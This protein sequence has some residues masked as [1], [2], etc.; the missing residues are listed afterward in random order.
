MSWTIFGKWYY[1]YFIILV[2]TLVTSLF[3]RPL[4]E[5]DSEA[6]LWMA[7]TVAQAFGA[8]MAIVIAIGLFEKARNSEQLSELAKE[9]DIRKHDNQ[10]NVRGEFEALENVID[11]LEEQRNMWPR[12]YYPLQSM[13]VL[14]AVSLLTIMLAKNFDMYF[15]CFF[16]IFLFLLSAYTLEVLLLEIYKTFNPKKDK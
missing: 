13:A 7:S 14:I 9:R 5:F 16:F 1:D 4:I 10:T 15:K 8:L 11:L 12:L 3:V 6:L 2:V